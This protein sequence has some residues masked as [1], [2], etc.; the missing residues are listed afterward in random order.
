MIVE[1]IFVINKINIEI[2]GK[3]EEM[4]EQIDLFIH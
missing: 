2:C 1:V 4:K 3:L